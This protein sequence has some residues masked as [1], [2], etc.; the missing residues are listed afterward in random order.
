MAA[1]FF[2]KTGLPIFVIASIIAGHA[3]AVTP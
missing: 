2:A 3:P 1:D